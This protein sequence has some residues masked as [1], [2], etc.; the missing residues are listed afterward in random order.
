MEFKEWMQTKELPKNEDGS[1]KDC[2]RTRYVKGYW[3]GVKQFKF[4]DFFLGIKCDIDWGELF[5]AL[6][7]FVMIPFLVLLI[8]LAPLIIP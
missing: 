8:P 3:W 6:L 5:K 2:P 1:L 7:F 4:S